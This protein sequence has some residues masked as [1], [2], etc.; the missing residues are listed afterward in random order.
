M[1]LIKLWNYLSGYVIIKIVGEYGERLLNQAAMKNL[2]LWD[3]KRVNDN[4]L[5]AKINVKDFFKL[6]RLAKKT[7]SRI[8]VLQRVGL[9]FTI[10]KLKKRKAFLFGALLF[11]VA[12]YLMSSFIWNI[13]IKCPDDDLSTSV[14]ED[15]RKWGLREGTFKYGL[16]KQYYLNKLL[17][18]YKNISWAE[19]EIRGSKLIVELVKKQLPPELEESTPCDIINKERIAVEPEKSRPSFPACSFRSIAIFPI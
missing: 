15:L 17:T 16:D 5:T 11:V 4:E 3:V 10:S 8:Y 6:A 7:R 9:F 19:I 14:I 1:L 12:I 18:K 2:Y 13:E